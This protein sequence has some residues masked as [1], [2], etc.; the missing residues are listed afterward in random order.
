MIIGQRRPRS[1]RPGCG[2]PATLWVTDHAGL[3]GSRGPGGILVVREI[4]HDLTG[5]DARVG[6]PLKDGLELPGELVTE[7]PL[8][9]ATAVVRSPGPGQLTAGLAD[10]GLGVSRVL[11]P[12][13]EDPPP[14][15][16]SELSAGL[17]DIAPTVVGVYDP[18]HLWVEVVF[19]SEL[20]GHWPPPL[21]FLSLRTLK[22]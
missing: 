15:A 5:T 11:V 9:F 14:I 22:P 2:L 3:H 7:E 17:A 4:Y 12:V 18:D 10:R 6:Q 16:V 13:G 8:R 20:C 1:P 19:P 21:N